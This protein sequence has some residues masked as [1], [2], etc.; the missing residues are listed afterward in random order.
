M[1][2]CAVSLVLA[3]E[4]C[5]ANIHLHRC[6]VEML[7]WCVSS[8][9]VLG[10]SPVN[11]CR[12]CSGGCSA[13][14]HRPHLKGCS[15][16]CP[17]ASPQGCLCCHCSMGMLCRCPLFCSPPAGGSGGC[18][19]AI[20]LTPVG[21]FAGIRL[22]HCSVEMLCWCP[23]SVSLWGNSPVSLCRHCSGGCSVGV[24]HPHLG[25]RSGRCPSA[26]PQRCLYRCCSGEMLCGC[27]LFHRPP[28][29]APLS[30]RPSLTHR[31][32]GAEAWAA[33]PAP[34]QPPAPFPSGRASGC[35][36]VAPGSTT[37]LPSQDSTPSPAGGYAPFYS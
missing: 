23:L 15:G 36:R 20:V 29:D 8:L 12:R 21:C 34:S 28:G 37:G 13:G 27:P 32:W 19:V 7:C 17:S 2:G 14:V 6:S 33:L 9:S 35:A 5:F 18:A 10:N 25:G 4:G 11:L 16:R 31:G 3:P 22:H 24:H 1:R 30:V 26:S